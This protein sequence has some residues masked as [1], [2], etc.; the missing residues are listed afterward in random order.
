MESAGMK[1]IESIFYI[2]NPNSKWN[3][4]NGWL[5]PLVA[6]LLFRPDYGAVSA[7]LINSSSCKARSHSAASAPGDHGPR[8]AGVEPLHVAQNDTIW[9][10]GEI[11][12]VL[13][14][15]TSMCAK[16]CHAC[17]AY[18]HH[19]HLTSMMHMWVKIK[20]GDPRLKSWVPF[21]RD[22]VWVHI[23][24]PQPHHFYVMCKPPSIV[25]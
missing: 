24:V 8:G 10:P 7:S 9:K 19:A 23:L 17:H 5:T 20:P 16:S 2:W 11:V 1:L 12:L 25:L 6:S 13:V 22:P 15:I 4:T 14:H 3:E 21:A 18:L